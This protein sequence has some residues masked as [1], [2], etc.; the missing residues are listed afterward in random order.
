[1]RAQR[2]KI[3][4]V[5]GKIVFLDYLTPER[6]IFSEMKTATYSISLIPF[7]SKIKVTSSRRGGYQSM[8]KDGC[9]IGVKNQ[10]FFFSCFFF[11]LNRVSIADGSGRLKTCVRCFA[12]SRSDINYFSVIQKK[13]L[14]THVGSQ[15][16]LTLRTA[17]NIVGNGDYRHK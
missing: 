6:K 14:Q 10:R 15:T 8:V 11:T 16:V 3:R 5:G 12:S 13:C 4:H 9:R 1:M 17:T 2:A 7:W